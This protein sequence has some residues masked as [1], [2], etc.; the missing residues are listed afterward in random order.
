[1]LKRVS[2]AG[3][4]LALAL[5]SVPVG[6]QEAVYGGQERQFG[7]LWSD[8]PNGYVASTLSATGQPLLPIFEGWYVN[9]DGTHDLSFSYLNMNLEQTFHIPI[10][11]NNY[12]EPAEFNGMQPTFFMPAPERGREGEQRHY[13]HQATFTVTLPAGFDPDQDVVWTLRYDGKTVK[14]P[15]RI[16][17]G[18][19][20]VE[21]LEAFTSAPVAAEMRLQP[22]GVGGRG[23]SGPVQQEALQTRV[24]QP[25]ELTVSVTPLNEEPHT[26]FWFD[27]QGPAAVSFQPQQLEVPGA[28]GNATVRATFSEPGEYMVRA[29][30][31]QTLASMVQHCCYTNGYLKVTVTP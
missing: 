24:G 29:T 16:R 5:A 21:N 22:S 30:A 11:Q 19:Y 17:V 15:G 23:R 27:H 8:W 10:G 12:L 9:E 13:R 26:V 7:G 14:V 20:R 3:A 28:G 1:M 2:C 25:A 31:V 4:V 18:S 6:A